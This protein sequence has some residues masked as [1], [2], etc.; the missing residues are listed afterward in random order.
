MARAAQEEEEKERQR[1]KDV[2]APT[3]DIRSNKAHSPHRTEAL[4]KEVSLGSSSVVGLGSNVRV[5]RR[6]R[7]GHDVAPVVSLWIHRN[8]PTPTP[9]FRRS[10][11]ASA[12]HRRASRRSKA[13]ASN[14]AW[15]NKGG[16]LAVDRPHRRRR[17]PRRS[18]NHDR[19]TDREGAAARRQARPPAGGLD[20]VARARRS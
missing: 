4:Y 12:R 2:S 18:P 19:Q 8:T 13:V 1:E 16:G 17:H 6:A 20:R 9:L 14:R 5:Q 10:A 3:V 7:H 15:P 11:G